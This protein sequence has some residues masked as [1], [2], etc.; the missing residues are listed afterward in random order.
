MFLRELR[1]PLKIRILFL[2]IFII[3]VGGLFLLYNLSV[4]ALK[5]EHQRLLDRTAGLTDNALMLTQTE[6]TKL[7]NLFQTN[8]SLTEY[9][10]VTT[11]LGGDKSAL[12]DLLYPT[13]SSLEIDS[14]GLYDTTGASLL[15]LDKNTPWTPESLDVRPG[16]RGRVIYG[17]KEAGGTIAMRAV[18]P[19]KTGERLLGYISIGKYLDQEYLKTLSQISGNEILLVKGDKIVDSSLAAKDLRYAKQG[20]KIEVAGQ[21]YSVLERK[22][23][24]PAGEPVG[25]MTI[26]LSDAELTDAVY[27]LRL[28]IWGIVVISS[29][30][31]ILLSRFFVKALS[32][33]LNKIVVFIGKVARGEFGEDLV[34]TGKD[35]IGE[36]AADVNNMKNQLRASRNLMEQYTE[37]LERA[38]EERSAELERVQAQL[39]HAQKMEAVGQLAGTIAHDFNNILTAII[40]YGELLQEG[41]GSD[42]ALRNYV[43]IIHNA[44]ER[45]SYMTHNLLAFSRKQVFSPRPVDLN[46]VVRKSRDFL[47][48]LIREDMEMKVLLAEDDL[49]VMADP[50]Q[51]EQILMNLFTNALDSMP[52]GGTLTIGTGA[53]EINTPYERAHCLP[54]K[55]AVVSVSDTGIGMD[56]TTQDSIFEPF[57]TTKKAG[58]G[59]GLGLSIV[60]GIVKQHGGCIEVS[61]EIGSGTTFKVYLPFSREIVEAPD[62]E[63]RTPPPGGRETVLLA[64]DDE[65]L[66]ELAGGQLQKAGY[67]VI[68][69]GDGEEAVTKFRNHAGK[70]DLL[71]LDVIMPKKN[72]RDVFSEIKSTCPGIKAIFLSGY[73]AEFIST[74]GKLEE[75]FN[76]IR[77][78]FSPYDLL[79]KVR[80]VLD[81]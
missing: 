23:K 72:G 54:G 75:G 5:S 47:S 48:R 63:K 78:P 46:Q 12:K 68:S 27:K 26:A 8:R 64:E 39:L 6:M 70:I 19:I 52:S 81:S 17:F 15:R 31:F 13:Y 2:P 60:R 51:I 55:Y 24:G 61:S 45:A 43:D 14:L 69:A 42:G 80:A 30:A 35:E 73:S 3:V 66:R 41:L 79:K 74:K 58:Q 49:V 11:V 25:I 67:H 4:K 62:R 44:A 77:K 33:P 56:R 10:Y 65:L 37:N 53:T 18:A 34:I 9:L 22:I 7:V 76:F 21:L 16:L 71:L 36:L 57:F 20:N 1:Y 40:G 38:V 29:L 50:V 32:D 59:T 28:S